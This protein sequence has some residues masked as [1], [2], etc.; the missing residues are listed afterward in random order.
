MSAV[1]HLILGILLLL[2]SCGVIKPLPAA[3]PAADPAPQMQTAAPPDGGPQGE[4]LPQLENTFAND[5]RQFV[6]S[7]AYPWSAVGRLNTGCTATLIDARLAVTAAHCVF[8]ANGQHLVNQY[9]FSP[10]MIRGKAAVAIAAT[11]VW[12]GTHTP[13]RAAGDDYAADWAILLLA[14][15]LSAFGSIPTRD[16]TPNAGDVVTLTGYSADGDN[17]LTATAHVNCHIQT[18]TTDGQITHDC[19]TTRGSSGGPLWS[20]AWG[21]TPAIV[22]INS[23]EQRDGGD[24][25]LK[26]KSYDGSHPNGAVPASRYFGALKWLVDHY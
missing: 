15:D 7:T 21:E 10:N 11:Y 13:L 16:V 24:V 18:G 9:S 14:H 23:T 2:A 8:D 6:T 20:Y 1:R 25:S 4:P 19:D 5:D 12:Y 26:L 3:Q 17:G 22:A